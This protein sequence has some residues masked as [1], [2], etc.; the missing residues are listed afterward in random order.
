MHSYSRTLDD[1]RAGLMGARVSLH[2]AWGDIRARYRRSVLGPFW[3]SLGTIVGVVG[4]GMV[5]RQLFDVQ[6]KE[7]IP[8]LTV[9]LIVWQLISGV[10]I[11]SCGLFVRQA[12]IIKNLVQPLS[13]HPLSLL[14]RHLVNFAHSFAVFLIVA[15]VMRVP[16][17]LATLLF[18]PGLLLVAVN[19]LWV[20]FAFGVL[21]SRY[22][23]LEYG[24]TSLMPIL[25]LIS[26]VMYRLNYLPLPS[27]ILQLN[28]F[29]YMIEIIRSP[30]MGHAPP[31]FYYVVLLVLA[32][33]G[34][35]ATLFLFHRAKLRLPF[36]I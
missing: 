15:L 28:P 1:L 18:L 5:W 3:Q 19:L 35:T 26:P 36:W 12:S 2:F 16:V 23:D 21:G 22:R 25:F 33:V 14:L 7:F 29:T 4:L 24:V 8:A 34:W 30:L 11:E 27:A 17:T 13:M 9:G 31:G 10:I 32:L 6:I 20:S